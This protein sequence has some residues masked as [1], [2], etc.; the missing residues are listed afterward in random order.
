MSNGDTVEHVCRQGRR[1]KARIRDDEG[2]FQGAGVERPNSLCRP[3]EESAFA[4][5]RELADDYLKLICARTQPRS[6]VSGPK[7]SGSSEPSIP[8]PL[9]VDTLMTAI[10][11]EATRWAL[12]ITHGE[13]LSP[14][15]ASQVLECLTILCSSLGTLVDLPIQTVTAWLPDAQGGDWDGRLEMDGVDAVLRL[16]SYHQ[17]AIRILG[18]DEPKE[19]WLH[20]FC[21]VCGLKALSM[22]M[23]KNDPTLASIHCRGCH[24]VWDQAEFTRLNNPLVA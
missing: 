5:I 22:R 4:D 1:C 18:L 15:P 24:N 21:H 2:E 23:D 6:K 10:D 8:I 12:R 3:C 19:E 11:N 16:S 14:N 20:E 17:R 13:P 7:V 9:A